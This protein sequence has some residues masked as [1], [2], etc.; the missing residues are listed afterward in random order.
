MSLRVTTRTAS[1]PDVVVLAVD[2]TPVVEL[3]DALV[4]TIAAVVSSGRAVVVDVDELVLSKAST[5]RR[6]LGRLLHE[7]PVEQVAF[8]CSRLTG[9]RILRRWGGDDLQVVA[10]VT[11]AM[12]GIARAMRSSDLLNA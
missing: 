8:S 3:L 9:R 4:E 2:G 7:V 5:L 1:T 12:P 10:A 6:F 11:E